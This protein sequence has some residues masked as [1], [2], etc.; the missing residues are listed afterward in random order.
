M[1]KEQVTSRYEEAKGAVKE[2]AGRVVGN[3]DLEAEGIVQ[4]NLGK[5]EAGVADLREDIKK[6]I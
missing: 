6:A 1:N 5:V 4:K 3:D 2:V